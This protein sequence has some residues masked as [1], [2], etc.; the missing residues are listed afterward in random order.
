[1]AKTT[2]NKAK[3]FSLFKAFLSKRFLRIYL[4]FL[5]IFI[6]AL[7]YY[8]Q[9]NPHFLEKKAIL[10]SMTLMN[11]NMFVLVIPPAWSLTYELYF[12][13]L[14]S[15]MLFSNKIKPQ[16]VFGTLIL[17]VIIKNISTPILQYKWLDFF[18]STLLFEF[19]TG[20]FLFCYLD[21]FSKKKLLPVNVILGAISLG[22][23]LYLTIA[24]G[25]VRVLT[26]G[27]FSF[28]LV[29]LFLL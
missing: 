6:L 11:P 4:G 18:L 3:G 23:G 27:V 9:F 1:M 24:Y 10:Q 25:Y 16:F 5:P 19:I 28:T 12:Y 17:L 8:Y 26:F 15:L 22:F 2:V 29:W 14:V 7:L 21:Q 13:L 20:Y